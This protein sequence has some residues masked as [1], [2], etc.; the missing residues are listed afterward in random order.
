MKTPTTLVFFLSVLSTVFASP[1]TNSFVPDYVVKKD[2]PGILIVDLYRPSFGF[3]QDTINAL[4]FEDPKNPKGE[5]FSF[6]KYNLTV[7]EGPPLVSTDP[8]QTPQQAQLERD[9][10]KRIVI[11]D[12][13][14]FVS[15]RDGIGAYLD[16][17]KKSSVSLKSGKIKFDFSF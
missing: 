15:T 14:V 16:N 17:S 11:N 12:T 9:T 10:N 13:R 8:L 2:L 7:V 3:K 4:A 6:G 1:P 5:R